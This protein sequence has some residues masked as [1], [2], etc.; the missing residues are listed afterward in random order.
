MLAFAAPTL[1]DLAQLEKMIARFR[2]HRASRRCVE[3]LAS[4][5]QPRSVKLIEASRILNDIFMQQLWSGNA[6]LY[7]NLKRDTTPL[8]QA[9]LHY[10]WINK[11]ALVGALTITP[12]FCPAS[13]RRSCRARISIRRI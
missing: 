12:R 3:S 4:G 9:R 5:S 11:G 13:L 10:F 6:E 2:A 8:G 7:Q 1:P